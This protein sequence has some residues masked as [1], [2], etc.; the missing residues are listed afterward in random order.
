MTSA[1]KAFVDSNVILYLFDNH[2]KKSLKAKEILSINPNINSQVLVEVV[3]VCKRKF[4]YTK[5]EC[6]SLWTDISST[7]Q[8][9]T[10][11]SS[12]IKLC[13]FLVR[14][15]DFQLFDSLIVASALENDCNIL[16]SEDMQNDM[17]VE[18][19]LK[20]INPFL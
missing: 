18:N 7:C 19:S 17:I 6:L 13:E 9:V 12:T 11:S 15:Y 14:K 4:G 8:I 3:N 1:N 5:E 10:I 2:S 20:I 16:Y